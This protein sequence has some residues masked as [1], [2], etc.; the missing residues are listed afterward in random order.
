MLITVWGY[1]EGQNSVF[2]LKIDGNETIGEL[3]DEIKRKKANLLQKIDADN[4]TIYRLGKEQGIP[5][6]Q[7]KVSK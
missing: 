2:P 7:I 1:V 5:R 6:I 3:K 4:L